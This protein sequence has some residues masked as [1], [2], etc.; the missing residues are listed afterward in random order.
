M[1]FRSILRIMCKRSIAAAVSIIIILCV[2]YYFI[3]ILPKVI[4][5]IMYFSQSA[6][7]LYKRADDDLKK[8]TSEN[9]LNLEPPDARIYSHDFMVKQSTINAVNSATES[10][11]ITYTAVETLSKEY[12]YIHIFLFSIN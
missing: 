5:K 10:L 1:S 12:R 11:T 7:T 3:F 6:V 4:N 9:K 2:I 8:P